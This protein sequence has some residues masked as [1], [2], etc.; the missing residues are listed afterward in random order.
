ML[1]TEQNERFIRLCRS[2]VVSACVTCGFA[3]SIVVLFQ[4]VVDSTASFL[5]FLDTNHVRFGIV[6]PVFIGMN[7]IDNDARSECVL[8]HPPNL[9]V[10]EPIPWHER[11]M[12]PDLYLL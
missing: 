3:G 1:N 4:F 11:S 8:A 5:P 10:S 2:S 9:K 7:F 12:M 6:M